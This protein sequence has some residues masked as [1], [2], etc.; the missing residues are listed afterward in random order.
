MREEER[1][2]ERKRENERG[3]ERK[4]EGGL[5]SSAQHHQEDRPSP[6]P[7]HLSMGTEQCVVVVISKS[8]G[9]E[10]DVFADL[11]VDTCLQTEQDRERRRETV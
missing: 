2:R 10:E 7:G 9:V 8:Q 3:R 1:G 4:R 5:A 11:L 6:S